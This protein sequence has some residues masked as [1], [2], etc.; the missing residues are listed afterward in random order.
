MISSDM[1]KSRAEIKAKYRAK[2]GILEKERAYA[3]ERQQKIRANW[4]PEELAEYQAK[5]REYLASEE[6]KEKAK[7]R[8]D[9][10]SAKQDAMGLCIGCAQP[11]T[12]GRY[13]DEHWFRTIGTRHRLH[14][15]NGGIDLLRRIWDEQNGICELTGETLVRGVNASLDHRV[16]KSKGGDNSRSNLRW[17][18]KIANTIK[19]DLTDE[20]FIALCRRI[21]A[22]HD[23][24]TT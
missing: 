1:P 22:N 12:A 4:S 10:W 5:Q 9:A 7:T 2:P 6:Q 17:V 8:W 3:R 11:A 18:H 24:R 23:R 20:E 13:C 14:V 15:M 16:P 21:V 19:K